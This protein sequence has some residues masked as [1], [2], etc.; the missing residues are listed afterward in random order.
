MSFGIG[1]SV[2]GIAEIPPLAIDSTACLA[3]ASPV[4]GCARCA[5]SCPTEAIRL[6]ENS[7][8]ADSSCCLGCGQCAVAC[9]TG[10]V[11]A[12]GFEVVDEHLA[13]FEC[14][15][16]QAR[17]RTRGAAA[18]PCLGGLTVTRYLGTVL[19]L[20]QSVVII[21][22]G[23]C[24]S[25]PAGGV[26]APWSTQVDE[27]NAILADLSDHRV[28]VESRPL[29]AAKADPLPEHLGASGAARRSL[30]RA[31]T[32]PRPERF[33]PP[34]R[35]SSRKVDPRSLRERHAAITALAA[36][37]GEPVAARHY[38]SAAISGDC[39]NSRVC[40][41]ACPTQALLVVASD[42]AEDVAF[43]PALCAA[44]RAC[45]NACPSGAFSLSDAGSGTFHDTVALRSSPRAVCHICDSDFTPGAGDEICQPCRRSSDLAREA[46]HLMRPSLRTT[47]QSEQPTADTSSNRAPGRN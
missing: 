7:I 39:C 3:M 10:A 17:E 29:P 44:C 35:Q 45:E 23:W 19:R 18:I 30:F 14:A 38:P 43:R 24:E 40:V 47:I 41:A 33:H 6:S 12:K 25:C 2:L 27:A 16:T 22:H 42:I 28:I 5:E 21:D 46:F 37:A 9:P 36:A 4:A 32:Q 8:A 13:T 26:E 34:A 20:R 1:D 31:F 11:S 15:R